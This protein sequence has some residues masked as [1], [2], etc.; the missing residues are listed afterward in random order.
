[1]AGH[2]QGASHLLQT[3]CWGLRKWGGLQTQIQTSALSPLEL[4][5][6]VSLLS[7]DS[8]GPESSPQMTATPN[9][10]G[11]SK[12][13]HRCPQGGMTLSWQ[14]LG[15]EALIRASEAGP[16]LGTGQ[17]G[18][19][20]PQPRPSPVP[21]AARTFQCCPGGAWELPCLLRAV[22]GDLE[23]PLIQGTGWG[24]ESSL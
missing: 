17:R 11:S 6:L 22:L 24:P 16:T 9:L 12:K 4:P 7:Q 3:V 13:A 8:L 1:M 20:S 14:E 2:S 21:R 10:P 23:W 15:R 5:E 19:K 18:P